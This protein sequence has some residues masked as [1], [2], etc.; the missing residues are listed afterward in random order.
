MKNVLSDK[1]KPLKKFE[2]SSGAEGES[3]EISHLGNILQVAAGKE[4]EVTL[5]KK[6]Y[7]SGALGTC[8]PGDC[9]NIRIFVGQNS[10]GQKQ[11]PLVPFKTKV[12][13]TVL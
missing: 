9:S 2:S 12:S 7:W 5:K 13:L 11:R 8:C 10:P 6:P 3:K 4:G 1:G